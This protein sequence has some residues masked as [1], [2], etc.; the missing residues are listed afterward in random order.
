M[1]HPW[2]LESV[3][4]MLQGKEMNETRVHMGSTKAGNFWESYIFST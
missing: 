4:A 2:V 1:V 3:Y